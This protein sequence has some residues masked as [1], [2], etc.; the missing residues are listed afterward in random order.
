MQ[1]IF[2]HPPASFQINSTSVQMYN[3][4]YKCKIISMQILLALHQ[5]KGVYLPC[6]F[7]LKEGYRRGVRFTDKIKE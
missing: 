5:V 7:M 1:S 3:E 6:H 4:K 2:A